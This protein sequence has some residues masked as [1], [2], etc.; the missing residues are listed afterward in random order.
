MAIN[1]FSNFPD[2]IYKGQTAKHILLRA[3]LRDVTRKATS[4]MLPLTLE[5]GE[6]T[7]MIANDLYKNSGYD[8][9]VKFSTNI[10]DPYFDWPLTD[11]DLE[12]YLEKKYGSLPAAQSTILYYTHVNGDIKINKDTYNLLT[13]PEQADYTPVYAYNEIVSN[14]DKKLLVSLIAPE[15]ASTIDN[16]LEKKL[17][18]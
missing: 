17:N 4:V 11:Y 5:Y 12:K 8:W 3:A 1:Y 9:L 16:E 15:F 13:G 14:N 2:I 6:R 7:D 10:I 18:E